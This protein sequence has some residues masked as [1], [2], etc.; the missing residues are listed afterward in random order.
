MYFGCSRWY[1]F[2]V[3]ERDPLTNSEDV[4]KHFTS[5]D[6]HACLFDE[7]RVQ[8]LHNAIFHKVH[9]GDVVVDA[10]SGTGLLGMLAARAGAK[11]V[12][13]VEINEEYCDVIRQN[14]MRNGLADRVIPLHGDSTEIDLPEAVDVIVSEV[15][16]CGFFYEPQLQIIENLKRFLKPGGSIIPGTMD[17]FVELIDAQEVLYDL[18]FTYESRWRDLDDQVLTTRARYLSTDFQK[19]NP[20]RISATAALRALTTGTANAVRLSYGIGF[21]EGV[22]AEQPT[23]F[24]LNPQIVFLTEPA[25]VVAGDYYDISLDYVASSSP[26][27][28]RIRVIRQER[29]TRESRFLSIAEPV[30]NQP[31][32]LAELARRRT[33]AAS[34]TTVD[35]ARFVPT[36]DRQ[37]IE[38]RIERLSEVLERRMAEDQR[39]LDQTDP[40]TIAV[41]RALDAMELED[42]RLLGLD[43]TYTW[44]D[45]LVGAVVNGGPFISATTMGPYASHHLFEDGLQVTVERLSADERVGLALGSLMR[46]IASISGNVRFVALLDD[47]T[48]LTLQRPLT[49]EEGDRFIVGISE[50]LEKFDVIRPSDIAGTHY[51]LLRESEQIQNVTTLIDLLEE[52]KAGYIDTFGDNVTYFPSEELIDKLA[53]RSENRA[54][55]FRRKG[56]AV[57]RNG[58]A[59]CQAID[60][61]TFLDP[62]N[63]EAVHAVIL[64]ERFASEQDKVYTLLRGAGVVSQSRYHNM[65]FDSHRLSVEL[66]SYALCKLMTTSLDNYCTAMRRFDTWDTFDPDEYVRRNYGTRIL[67]EDQAIMKFFTQHLATTFSESSV[68]LVADIGA[69][70]NLYP[71][72][73]LTPYLTPEAHL[74]MIEFTEHNQ[75][76]LRGVLGDA[77]GTAELWRPFEQFMVDVIDARYE[78]AQQSVCNHGTVVAGSIFSMPKNRYDVVNAFFSTESVTASRSQFWDTIR[79]VASSVKRG[80]YVLGAHML[81]S[82]EWH[83]GDETHFPAVALTVDDIREAYMDAD[84]EFDLFEFQA[85][86]AAIREGYRGVVAVFARRR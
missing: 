53:M 46:D 60:A 2:A 62:H 70:P 24:L 18:R 84:L 5:Y 42:L 74:D 19:E 35:L 38:E 66:V 67:P 20:F 31:Q 23:E 37:V 8:L 44:L 69:G 7:R 3:Q 39:R 49:P 25:N 34:H 47:V 41:L 83:A 73:M 50:V 4:K 28:C 22:Y 12:Y 77:S 55:E 61:A 52:G 80:G 43:L 29:G 65:F 75:A 30:V 6:I 72:M 81:G 40:T 11:R 45:D 33:A 82:H 78:G 86:T 13:C 63:R 27:D 64:D 1:V 48:T 68:D 21:S 16:S 56:I 15:I 71:S 76:Y 14:A 10:G 85:G 54:R 59:T 17:N 51:L 58:K 36:R 32:K 57:V 9:P 79:S 26:Q